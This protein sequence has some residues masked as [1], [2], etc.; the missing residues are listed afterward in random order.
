MQ[1]EHLG[2]SRP[3]LL[4]NNKGAVGAIVYG[5]VGRECGRM[6]VKC[7]DGS[8]GWVYKRHGMQRARQYH[9]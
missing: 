6:V 5:S 2:R 8:R 7:G 3:W 9:R 1:S 4:D